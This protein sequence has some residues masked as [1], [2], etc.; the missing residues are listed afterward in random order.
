MRVLRFIVRNWAL[1]IGAVVLAVILYVAMVALQT[2]QQW[3]GQ[4]AIEVVNQPTNSYMTSTLPQVDNIKYIAA[5]D[6]PISQSSFRATVDLTDAKVSDSE[7]TLVKVQ[8]VADDPRVQI[9]DYQP[10]QI[11]VTLDP[12]VHR[13]VNIQ[14]S[15]GAVPSGLQPGTPI[16]SAQSVDVSGASSIVSKVA[17]AEAAVRIDASG[18]DVN[19]DVDLV[20]RD[21]SGAPVNNVTFNPRTVHVQMLV[22][23]QTRSETVPVS[24]AITGS[25]AAGYYITSIDITPPAV[26]VRGQADALALLKGT[27]NT[28]PISIAGATGDVSVNVDLDLPSG[29]TSD[30][31]GTIAIVVHLQSP[32]STRSVSVGIVPIGAQSD[33]IYTLS[34]PSVTVTIGGAT[35]ALNALDTS[36]LVASVPVGSLGLGTHTVTVSITTPAGIKV[37]AISPIQITV[38]VAS[39][40]SPS[41]VASPT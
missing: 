4:I 40:P 36:T 33:R 23:S 13:Q 20:A 31:T 11:K 30:T 6:V 41:P 21:A 8:L 35:A 9:I 15:T 10:Q 16:L 17:Y 37:V 38:T 2:T 28:K 26:S 7:F 39:A 19:E 24:P 14:V 12:I 32:S 34:T 1:K 27:A 29:V 3:P 22:G 5:G 25:P 18:L